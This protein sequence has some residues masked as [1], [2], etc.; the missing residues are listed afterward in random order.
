MPADT[1]VKATYADWA[2]NTHSSWWKDPGL[3][4]C[5]LYCVLLFFGIFSGGYDGSLLNGLQA[6]PTWN[7]YFGSPSGSLLGIT[8]ASQYLSGIVTTPLVSWACDKFG[9]KLT[10][11]GGSI[12]MIIGAAIMA[13]SNGLGMFIGARVIIGLSTGFANI[14]CVCLLNE[15]AHPRLRGITA[16]LY[17]TTYYV[18]AIVSAWS[19][20]GCVYWTSSSWSWRLPVLLQ[21]LGPVVMILTCLFIV[22]ESPR[23]LIARGQTE[24]AHAILADLHANG[25]MDDELVLNEVAEITG[26]IKL[27]KE[28]GDTSWRRLFSTPGNRRRMLVILTVGTGTQWNGI[29]IISYYLAPVLRSVGITDSVQIAGLN[30]GLSDWFM[31]MLGAVLV[32]RAGRRRLWLTSTAG[33]LVAFVILTALSAEFLKTQNKSMGGGVP[34]SYSYTLEVLPYGIRA[35]GM[36][37][38]AGTQNVALAFNQYVNPVA[39]QK[40]AWKYYIVYVVVI[41]VYLAIIYFNFIETKGYTAEECALLLDQPKGQRTVVKELAVAAGEDKITAKDLQIEHRETA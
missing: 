25:K 7:A 32:N 22:P 31:A 21:A 14:G 38:F 6:M 17:L 15:L 39:L 37:L 12:F 10:I 8:G 24:K 2:N 9:R 11:I 28:T 20:F 35:K 30:G 13:A 29:G 34:L 40:I 4:R 23:Y 3:R 41:S 36:S 5:T 19:T 1:P 27:E 16:A 33:L 26:A 18:G